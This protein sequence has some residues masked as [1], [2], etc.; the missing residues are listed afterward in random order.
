M[1]RSYAIVAVSLCLP[2]Q[3][4]ADQE[5]PHTP[6]VFSAP[7]SEYYFKIVPKDVS[8]ESAI[9]YVYR[10]E[11]SR[12]RLIYQT[13]GWYSF[14]VLLS[15]TGSKIARRGPWARFD[16]PPEKTIAIAFYSQGSPTAQ[17]VVSDLLR[18]LT[19]IQRSVSHYE[20]GSS[21]TWVPGTWPEQIQVQTYDGQNI[22]FD[23]DSGKI[24]ERRRIT[25]RCSGPGTSAGR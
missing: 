5:R 23:M 19:C 8:D 9:G 18:D 15:S 4:L 11:A 12:D 14:E 25:A 6:L 16:S 10:V 21:I 20:W 3:S 24:L 13:K 2:F 1:V 7:S 22:V 17:Y